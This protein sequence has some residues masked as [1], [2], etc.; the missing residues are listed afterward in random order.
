MGIWFYHRFEKMKPQL[1]FFLMF[2]FSGFRCKF[3]VQPII[4][5]DI[6]GH[7]S[8][9]FQTH[10]GGC[11]NLISVQLTANC[12]SYE[13]INA[14]YCF[15]CAVRPPGRLVFYKPINP[16]YQASLTVLQPDSHPF[17][18]LGA[19]VIKLKNV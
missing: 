8:N 18:W 12:T 17:T 13:C 11:L 15:P 4:K 5:F 1:C 9:R 14:N 7:L 16:T 10:T 3:S 19:S 6:N 2:F